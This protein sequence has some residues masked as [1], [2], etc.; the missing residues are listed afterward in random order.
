MTQFIEIL[1]SAIHCVLD[2]TGCSSIVVLVTLRQGGGGREREEGCGMLA[3]KI[4]ET[5][6]GLRR[7]AFDM[8]I[9]RVESFSPVRLSIASSLDAS[10]GN[11]HIVALTKPCSSSSFPNQCVCVLGIVLG[12]MDTV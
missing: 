9:S 4:S 6:R 7:S 2:A 3:N 8:V 12:I 1:R 5:L 11:T 10:D